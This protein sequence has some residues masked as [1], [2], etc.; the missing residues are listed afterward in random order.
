MNEILIMLVGG[1]A[2]LLLAVAIDFLISRSRCKALL[3]KV[4]AQKEAVEQAWVD[5]PGGLLRLNVRFRG[6]ALQEAPLVYGFEGLRE[7]LKGLG[8][9]F[10]D[11][12]REGER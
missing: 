8:V 1:L 4:G 6:E 7:W 5:K 9:P 12:R 2:A 10:R 11:L 3:A